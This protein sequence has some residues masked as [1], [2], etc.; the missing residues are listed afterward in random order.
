MNVLLYGVWSGLVQVGCCRPQSGQ[1]G[2]AGAHSDVLRQPVRALLP[3]VRPE[4]GQ[5]A[6]DHVRL[7]CRRGRGRLR[8]THGRHPLLP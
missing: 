7:L 1:R 2:A 8:G 4:R 5:E 6:R 3:Q